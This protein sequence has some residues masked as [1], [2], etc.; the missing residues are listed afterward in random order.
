MSATPLSAD[1]QQ[2]RAHWDAKSDDYQAQHDPQ[3]S[4]ERGWGVWNIP[5]TELRVLG[6][7]AGRDIL[8][9]GCGGAQW[10]IWLA[11]Q[12]ARPVGLDN[13]ERQ[14]AHA[15]QFMARAGV[16]FPLVHASADNAPLPDASFDV[17]FCDHGA[18]SF[19][20][21]RR[22]VPEVA[23]LLRPGG[24]FAFSIAHPVFWICWDPATEK[25]GDRL[26]GDYF[27]LGREVSDGQV[28]YQAPLS[29]WVRL[30][31]ANGFTIEDFLELQPPAN[32]TTTYTDYVDL[33]WARRWPSECLWRL[34]RGRT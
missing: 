9:F 2:N 21:P 20:D 18:M 15:R 24:L 14:L 25:T 34:R 31:C 32:A 33:A 13:S 23:R 29:E 1:A 8:E 7:V 30:F 4:G 6:E 27:G 26:I 3:L 16:D 12:G 5:E 28:E 10:S 17:V 22:T 11:Q 19:A